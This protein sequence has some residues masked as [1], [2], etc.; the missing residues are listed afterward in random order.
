[1]TNNRVN[2][3]SWS[4]LLGTDCSVVSVII[5]AILQ[6]FIWLRPVHLFNR[7]FTCFLFYLISLS[8]LFHEAV[9]SLNMRSNRR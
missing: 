3:E 4:V 8:L 2:E 1:V 6:R 9:I 7:D 5:Y